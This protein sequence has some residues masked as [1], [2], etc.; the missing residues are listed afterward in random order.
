MKKQLL[1]NM[2]CSECQASSIKNPYNTSL[3]VV[4]EFA[5][6]V[7]ELIRPNNLRAFK[8]AKSGKFKI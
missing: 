7:T 4:F 2:F 1:C 5:E 3:E 8:V 6:Y